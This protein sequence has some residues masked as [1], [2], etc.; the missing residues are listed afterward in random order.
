MKK[1]F[2]VFLF[3]TACSVFETDY[4]PTRIPCQI[5]I[6]EFSIK[7]QEIAIQNGFSIG[8][9]DETKTVVEYWKHCT[10]DISTVKFDITSRL[11]GTG[12]IEVVIEGYVEQ[13]DAAHY[14]YFNEQNL[15][16][17]Y[18]SDILPMMKALRNMCAEYQQ[19]DG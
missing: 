4:H 13:L 9:V 17:E 3:F 11:R 6:D 14:T 12:V 16:S 10:Y 18:R 2:L 8:D 19:V 7:V 15:P 1:F 5:G